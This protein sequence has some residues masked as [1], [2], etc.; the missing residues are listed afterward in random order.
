M[1]LLRI[2]AEKASPV[3]A[4]LLVAVPDAVPPA[5]TV[6]VVVDIVLVSVDNTTMVVCWA[7]MRRDVIRKTRID[8]AR[9]RS[10][11][12]HIVDRKNAH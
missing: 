10:N 11:V 7:V 2:A 1:V 3:Y 12:Q 5:V 8:C 4:M 6:V 9:A